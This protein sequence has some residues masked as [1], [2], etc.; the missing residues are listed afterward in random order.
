MGIPAKAD[1]TNENSGTELETNDDVEVSEEERFTTAVSQAVAAIT[2][3]DDGKY[4]LPEGLSMEMRM[5]VIAEKRRRDTQSEFTKTSQKAKALEAE[6]TALKKRAIGNVKIELTPELREELEDLKFSD[7]EEWRKRMNKLEQEAFSK[8]K[9]ELDD[10]M[11][12]V[13][14]EILN[15]DELERREEVL[16]EFLKSHEGF[17]LNDDILANDIP[18]RFSKRL[19]TGEISF[20]TFLQ[21]V[22]DY[23]KTG[24][25][26]KQ[27]GVLNQPNLSKVGGSTSPEKH[28]ERVDIIKS[29]EKEV[30]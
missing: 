26:I 1:T 3:G 22:Y 17:E 15:K 19:E 4:I 18:P 21:E 27:E 12:Q 13:S 24:K 20:E 8:H 14:T 25:V 29:Y 30:F 6:N 11:G 10:E 28:A 23:T 9:K 5:A 2:R 7:P 16:K